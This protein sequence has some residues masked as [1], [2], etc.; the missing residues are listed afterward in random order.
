M[1]DGNVMNILLILL[2]VIIFIFLMR[3]RKRRL[4]KQSEKARK[5]QELIM[6][7][8]VEASNDTVREFIN[9]LKTSYLLFNNPK[10]REIAGS[11]FETV[12]ANAT[13]DR[14]LKLELRQALIK[15]GVRNLKEIGT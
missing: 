7:F 12:E 3:Y 2:N 1:G 6:Q 15:Q 13:V 14:E 9:E 8:S 11:F 10:N 4:A 5:L